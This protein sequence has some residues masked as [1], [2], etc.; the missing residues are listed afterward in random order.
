MINKS[1]AKKNTEKVYI[2][3]SIIEFSISEE[4]KPAF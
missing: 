2:E 1:K 4:E 3:F